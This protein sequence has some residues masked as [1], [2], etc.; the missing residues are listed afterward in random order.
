MTTAAPT[1]SSPFRSGAL[2]FQWSSQ[3][4]YVIDLRAAYY[5]GCLVIAAS[6][7]DALPV[8][9]QKILRAAVGKGA[10]RMEELGRQQDDA[11]LGGLFER[12]G[13]HTIPVSPAFRTEFFEASRETRQRLGE[14]VVPSAL[15]ARVMS[16]LGDF[17]G[18]QAP[19]K[20]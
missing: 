10:A 1:R 2:A 5:V 9:Q 19:L 12:Q 15:I 6:A 8:E 13:L 7:F 17:R 20:E 16:W 14:R 18:E 4:R 3:A 11:L